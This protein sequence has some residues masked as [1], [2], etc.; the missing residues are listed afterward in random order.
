MAPHAAAAGGGAPAGLLGSE[1]R[2]R[3]KFR[4]CLS[5]LGQVHI[6]GGGAILIA[7]RQHMPA[8]AGAV[9]VAPKVVRNEKC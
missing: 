8:V 5:W 9:A 3:A 6:L 1:R 2:A 7:G 4:L